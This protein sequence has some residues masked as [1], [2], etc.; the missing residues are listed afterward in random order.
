MQAGMVYLK[1]A[2]RA[3]PKYLQVLMSSNEFL[4]W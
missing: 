3:W 1:T 4:Y 2:P